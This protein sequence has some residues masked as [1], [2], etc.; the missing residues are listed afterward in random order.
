MIRK[1]KHAVRW[2]AVGA[3]L[4]YVFDPERGTARREALRNQAMQLIDRA[5]G[6]A[7]QLRDDADQVLTPA[8]TN[9]QTSSSTEQHRERHLARPRRCVH[10]ARAVTLHRCD[11]RAAISRSR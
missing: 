5:K 2:V 3:A 4:A 9:G 11:R 7:A 1:M 6:S 8:E 10:G